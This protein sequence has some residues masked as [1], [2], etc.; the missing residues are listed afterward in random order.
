MCVTIIITK[1]KETINLGVK[2]GCMGR[3]G[4]RVPGRAGRDESEG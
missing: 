1:E 3:V 4:G 2:V